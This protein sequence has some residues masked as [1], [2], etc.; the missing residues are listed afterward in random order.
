MKTETIH[1]VEMVREIRDKQ[2]VLYWQDKETY[3]S[4]MRAAAGRMNQLLAERR[5]EYLTKTCD[6]E[7]KNA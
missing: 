3:L 6:E 1:A 4:E 7:K 2:A 5:N